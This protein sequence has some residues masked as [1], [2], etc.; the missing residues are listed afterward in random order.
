MAGW[1]GRWWVGVVV[2]MGVGVGCSH[3]W[4]LTFVLALLGHPFLQGVENSFPEICGEMRSRCCKQEVN[5][6]R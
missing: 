6:E 1:G 5:P 4:H 3:E 2:V